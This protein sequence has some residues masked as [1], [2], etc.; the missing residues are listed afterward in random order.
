[1]HIKSGA[2]AYQTVQAKIGDHQCRVL[3]DG[4]S[5][6]S[7]ISREH[8]RKLNVRPVRTEHCV[9]GT[10]NGDMEVSCPICKLRVDAVGKSR[11]SFVTEFAQL[12]LFMLNS[13]LEKLVVFRR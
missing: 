6:G 9:I 4:G 10:V 8:R 3:L 12:D 2:V 11:E 5:G 13:I 7:Y 1:M